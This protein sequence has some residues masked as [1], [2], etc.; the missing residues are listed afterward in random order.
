MELLILLLVFI[1]VAITAAALREDKIFKY[2]DFEAVAKEEVWDAPTTSVK[3]APKKKAA[4]KK[5]APAKKKAAKK[6]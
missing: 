3:K 6:K 1:G 5:A 4:A 2:S